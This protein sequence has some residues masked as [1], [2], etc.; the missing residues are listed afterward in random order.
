VDI[1]EEEDRIDLSLVWQEL[2]RLESERL[3]IDSKLGDYLKE[4]GYGH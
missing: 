2:R 3:A 4:L 1:F